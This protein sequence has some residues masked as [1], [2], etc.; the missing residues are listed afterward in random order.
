MRA[1]FRRRWRG[2][3]AGRPKASVAAPQFRTVIGSFLRDVPSGLSFIDGD[4][5]GIATF[6]SLICPGS[7]SA[8]EPSDAERSEQLRQDCRT[9]ATQEIT[10][11]S[12]ALPF[13]EG[14]MALMGTL[15]IGAGFTVFGLN[16]ALDTLDLL[17]LPDDQ[18]D[19]LA[20]R[21]T[22]MVAR[23]RFRLHIYAAHLGD[24][25]AAAKLASWSAGFA[26]MN[27]NR[28][29]G[30]PMLVAALGWAER[31]AI[32]HPAALSSARALGL[33]DVDVLLAESLAS[34]LDAIAADL[35]WAVRKVVVVREGDAEGAQ[36]TFEALWR[37]SLA[38]SKEARRLITAADKACEATAVDESA[39]VV[40]RSIAQ[41]QG[42]GTK[43]LHAD[44]ASWVGKDVPLVSTGNIQ[45]VYRQLVSEV[46]HAQLII[47]T[48][49][50]DTAASRMVKWRP[51]LICGKPGVSK[52]FL[53]IRICQTMH[54]PY[55]I[56]PCGG[57]SDSSYGGTSRQW[58]TGR[59]SVPLQTI[60]QHGVGNVVQILDEIDK[61][62]DG[63]NRRNGSLSDVLLAML[64]PLSSSNSFDPYLEGGPVS[65]VLA[66][67]CK[68]LVDGASRSAGQISNPLYGGAA[69]RAF[70]RCAAGCCSRDLGAAWNVARMD[71]ALRHHG[72][73]HDPESLER[74]F[75]STPYAYHRGDAGCP[76]S[77]GDG[78]LI[79]YD[80]FWREAVAHR[81]RR[82]K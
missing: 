80:H 51:T 28:A 42:L 1:A 18:D 72:N 73:Q 13:V 55:R 47:D 76:R 75:D 60:C 26:L 43:E 79:R 44:R 33:P 62:A 2:F 69:R 57:A 17:S 65:R 14:L 23:V 59:A 16:A 52:T 74:R 31:S 3:V 10:S 27:L 81:K 34:R 4:T 46:P 9:W 53:A 82:S 29:G 63:S 70:T 68:R 12:D 7:A 78:Q 58:A 21:L 39:I 20:A 32:A 49:L 41:G 67:H 66:G 50:R 6:A 30:W 64:E 48:I 19:P 24:P 45:N 61:S 35:A 71:R 22:E 25:A 15:T 77:A 5:V 54:L 56:V 40:V 37:A 36:R 11:H 8:L 38:T